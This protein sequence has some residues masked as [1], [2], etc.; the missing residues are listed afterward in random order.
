MRRIVDQLQYPGKLVGG[1]PQGVGQKQKRGKA[2]KARFRVALSEKD[3]PYRLVIGV[4]S[5]D[6][7]DLRRKRPSI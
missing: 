3:T 2:Q 5:S 6:V 4:Q 1:A 7:D